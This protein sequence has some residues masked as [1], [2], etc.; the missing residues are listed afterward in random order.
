MILPRRVTIIINR[1]R[2]YLTSVWMILKNDVQHVQQQEQFWIRGI[3]DGG[4][5]ILDCG[6]QCLNARNSPRRQSRLQIIARDRSFPAEITQTRQQL[7]LGNLGWGLGMGMTGQAL[8]IA[9]VCNSCCWFIIVRS[10]CRRKGLSIARYKNI[11][12]SSSLI[13]ITPG[14]GCHYT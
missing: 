9:L 13:M 5:S 8:G 3:L 1:L 14:Y 12:K 10:H 2:K 6:P 7:W 11:N 4:Y